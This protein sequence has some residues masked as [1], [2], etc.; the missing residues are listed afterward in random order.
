MNFPLNENYTEENVLCINSICDNDEELKMF[1]FKEEIKKHNCEFCSQE[2]LWN[3]KKLEFM[4]FRKVKKYNNL[5]DNI[6]ILCP[7]CYSQ[8]NPI[9]IKTKLKKCIDCGKRIKQLKKNI[10]LDPSSEI[11]NPSIGKFAYDRKR[12]DFCLQQIVSN[13]KI[14]N[15]TV[16]II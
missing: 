7:N 15:Y 3:G 1:L 14:H 9:K 8:K 4:I 6:K 2:P 12:C 5:L 13:H 16:K 10:F 11:I